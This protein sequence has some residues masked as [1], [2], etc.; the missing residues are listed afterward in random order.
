MF[1]ET[2]SFGEGYNGESFTLFLAQTVTMSQMTRQNSMGIQIPEENTSK[3]L[4]EYSQGS[5]PSKNEKVSSVLTF[6]NDENYYGSSGNNY[7]LPV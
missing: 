5:L 2:Q 3:Q 1:Q 4:L 6:K 7:F